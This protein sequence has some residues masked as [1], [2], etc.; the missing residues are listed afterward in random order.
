MKTITSLLISIVALVTF[1]VLL[2]YS[3]STLLLSNHFYQNLTTKEVH[4][5]E[6]TFVFNSI[7]LLILSFVSL[8]IGFKSFMI[9]MANLT[10]DLEKK[11]DNSIK[12]KLK[13]IKIAKLYNDLN[14]TNEVNK[15][16][17][18]V[19]DYF[20]DKI[21]NEATASLKELFNQVNKKKLN[22]LIPPPFKD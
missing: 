19:K 4:S 20:E 6:I 15:K 10:N 22:N 18:L 17:E 11:E 3:S 8:A 16:E 5:F 12:K 7:I 1:I 21:V 13:Y 2:I 14:T 9:F